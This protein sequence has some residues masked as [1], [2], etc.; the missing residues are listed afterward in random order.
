MRNFTKIAKLH[1]MFFK[2]ADEKTFPPGHFSPDVNKPGPGNLDAQWAAKEK[3]QRANFN[4]TPDPGSASNHGIWTPKRNLGISPTPPKP[5]PVSI[6]QNQ[7]LTPKPWSL[8]APPNGAQRQEANDHQD[9][10]Q[11]IMASPYGKLL[12]DG[13]VLPGENEVDMSGI[14]RQHMRGEHLPLLKSLPSHR[15]IGIAERENNLQ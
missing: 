14:T 3:D 6:H 4:Y 15:P 9:Y 5:S 2:R 7:S 12:E 8:K 1:R 10:M 11:R 13:T